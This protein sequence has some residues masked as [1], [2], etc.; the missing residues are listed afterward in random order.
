VL[1]LYVEGH[2]I[3]FYWSYKILLSATLHILR[4]INITIFM[5]ISHRGGPG[6]RPGLVKWNLWGIKLPWGRFSPSTSVSAANLHS[7]KS[8]ILKITRGRNNRPE[9]ADVSSGPRMD[10]ISHYA[11]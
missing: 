6:S 11:N 3:D 10:S 5:I 9:V 1:G 8:S 2:K 7:T 4:I